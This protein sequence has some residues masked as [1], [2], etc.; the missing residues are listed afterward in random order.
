VEWTPPL[1]ADAWTALLSDVASAV[2]GCDAFAVRERA[3]RER[4]GITLLLGGADG[5]VAFVKVRPAA[6]GGLRTERRVLEEARHRPPAA[7]HLPR[8]L[9]HGE[10]GGWSWLALSVLPP[11]HR[12]PGN[13]RLGVVALEVVRLLRGLPRPDGTP[14]HWLPMHGDLTPWNLR[15]ADGALWLFDWE[16][17]AWAPPGADRVLYR[18]S[19]GAMRGA[20]DANALAAC[21]YWPE[22]A[23][24]W[25]GR[26]RARVPAGRGERRLRARM[27]ALLG[28][29]DDADGGSEAGP[30][31]APSRAALAGVP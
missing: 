26:V 20:G 6:A 10:A 24:F 25:A 22:A 7:F 19:A 27:L 5:P 29:A 4:R 11:L 9:G 2:G 18:V 23:S 12:P 1:P 14:R 13:P 30:S 31:R 16:R 17:A 28:A 3:Q 21:A 15:T 8:V